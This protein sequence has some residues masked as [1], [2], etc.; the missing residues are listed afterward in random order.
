MQQGKQRSI[1]PPDQCLASSDDG[2]T[3]VS[4]PCNASAPAQNWFVETTVASNSSCTNL[5]DTMVGMHQDLGLYMTKTADEC[6]QLC[7]ANPA[8]RSWTKSSGNEGCA[9]QSTDQPRQQKS[10]WLSG[11]CAGPAPSLQ[12]KHNQTGKCIQ[13]SAAGVVLAPCSAAQNQVF[14]RYNQ[15]LR[16]PGSNL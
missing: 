8:C 1:M 9:L 10:G 6:C 14:N 11:L 2:T 12:L 16:S 4:R 13:T 7:Q 15:G 5:T 3:V